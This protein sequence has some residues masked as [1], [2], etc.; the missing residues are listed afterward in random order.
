M[1]NLSFHEDEVHVLTTFGRTGAQS[2]ASSGC[3][4]PRRDEYNP[5]VTARGT[6]GVTLAATFVAQVCGQRRGPAPTP[7]RFRQLPAVS[8]DGKFV[9]V[10]ITG[11]DGARGNDNLKIAIIDVDADRIVESIVIV[12]PAH[13]EK[14]GRAKREA[15]AQAMLAKRVWRPMGVLELS[16]DPK[17][18]ARKGPVGGP[19]VAQMAVGR[20]LRVNYREPMLMVRE[21]GP[22]GRELVRRK[23]RELSFTRRDSC[24]GCDCPAPFASIANAA[25]DMAARVLLLEIQYDGGSD[26]CWEPD[27]SFHAIRLPP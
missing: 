3:E 17:A 25:V 27:D 4:S 20:G 2:S 12:D 23:A 8:D 21:A 6:I 13:P 10:T 24:R 11:S 14:R 9:A 26:V 16:D 15:E 7:A 5:A 18:P 19:F 22:K 1:R